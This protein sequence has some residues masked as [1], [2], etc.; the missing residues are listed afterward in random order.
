MGVHYVSSSDFSR[1][2]GKAKKSSC[3]GPVF[4]TNRDRPEH[5][6]MSIEE[7]RRML[8]GKK[9]LAEAMLPGSELK[10][11]ADIEFDPPRSQFVARVPDLS[12]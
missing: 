8:I 4:I 12:E 6:L 3:L 11:I 7:Y 5:V 10:G 2:P 9:S 1:D